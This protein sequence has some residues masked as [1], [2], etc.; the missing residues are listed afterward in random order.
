M[1]KT[2]EISYILSTLS[3]T[4]SI[5]VK[6]KAVLSSM[7]WDFVLRISKFNNLLFHVA[8]YIFEN[9]I[10]ELPNETKLKVQTIVQ[11]G[12]KKINDIKI[13]LQ[14]L[15]T[16][17]SQDIILI[18][19]YRIHD[20]IPNDIDFIVSNFENAMLEMEH[21]YGAG[22]DLDRRTKEILYFSKQ[23]IKLH[24]HGKVAWLG[25]N[26]MSHEDIFKSPRTE[27]YSGIKVKVPNYD[28]DYLI[29]IAHMNFEPMHFTL[30]ELVYLYSIM[31]HVNLDYCQLQARKNHWKRS[32]DRTQALLNIFFLFLFEENNDL[33]L[34][35][36]NHTLPHSFKR[37]HII[38]SFL[39]KGILVEPLKKLS[40]VF[41]VLMS[42]DT[43]KDF[44]QSPE[45]NI[46][47]N[48]ND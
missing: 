5:G 7:D 15:I 31:N 27:Y 35:L 10:N 30:S 43:Y 18:K 46:S 36:K 23:N 28:I 6:R 4:F 40:K 47:G 21:L 11:K 42:G 9:N 24:L 48:I 38:L 3:K 14:Q 45:E 25:R 8:S 39:E 22:I 20:R 12:E 37:T 32:F 29:H 16:D 17:L 41:K 19:T 34:F 1:K 33:N 13:G 26:Y 2:N 44:Y